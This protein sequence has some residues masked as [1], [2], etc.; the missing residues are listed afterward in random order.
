M[1][2]KQ[3]DGLAMVDLKKEIFRLARN[4]D[5]LGLVVITLI[6]ARSF[7]IYFNFF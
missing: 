5:I 1:Y 2:R 3:I 6:I 4:R 7:S